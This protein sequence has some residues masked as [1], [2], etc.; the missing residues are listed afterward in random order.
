MRPRET[1]SLFILIAF[2]I[3]LF[4]LVGFNAPSTPAY[5][6][7]GH[8]KIA[9]QTLKLE[10]AMSADEQKKGLSGRD[11]LPPDTGMLFIFDKPASYRFWMKD[12]NFPIDIIWISENHKVIYIA[13]SLDPKTYPHS[14]GP[15]SDS[16]YVLEAVSGF[17]DKNNLR[18]GDVISFLQ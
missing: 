7:I 2:F 5:A 6:D 1:Y 8:I 13:K 18:E 11:I 17:S 10:L 15:S 14:F 9:G 4:K 3:V 16:K 12:M